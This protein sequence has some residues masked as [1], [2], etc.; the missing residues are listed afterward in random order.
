MKNTV[1]VLLVLAAG[2]AWGSAYFV[3]TQNPLANDNH[4]GTASAPFKTIQKAATIAA[5][6][7]TVYVKAGTYNERVSVNRSGAP[8]AR[9]VFKAVPRRTVTMQGFQLYGNY[10]RI[11]GF[12]L[13]NA[14]TGWN[15][16]QGIFNRQTGIQV[17]D[18]YLYNLTRSAIEGGDSAYIAHNHIYH[19]AFGISVGSN[20][21]VEYNDVERLYDYGNQDADYSR[22]GGSHI[23][24]RYNRY[25]G[26]LP[27]EKKTSHTDCWQ[28][29]DVNGTISTDIV[30][31][32]NF[33]SA[34]NQGL[35]GEGESYHQSGR[36]TFKN[37]IF[38]DCWS[39]GLCVQDIFEITAIHNVFAFIGT[40]G[41]GISGGY[42][43]NNIIKNNIFYKCG[44]RTYEF[45]AGSGSVGDYNIIYQGFNPSVP[46]PH[47]L[48]QVDPLFVDPDAGDFRLLPNSPA[49]DAGSDVGLTI[50]YAG[51]LRPQ[52]AGF[53]IGPYEADRT[54]PLAPTGLTAP[55]RT[56]HI[57]ALAW[58]AP[59]AASDG[60]LAAGYVIKRG[61]VH[62]GTS[63]TT[64]FN[65]SN[66]NASTSYSYEVYA[67]DPVGNISTGAATGNFQT[68]GDAVG[69][70]VL[71]AL[72]LSLT[73]VQV[74]FDEPV[75]QATSE[76]VASYQLSGGLTVSSATRQADERSVIVTTSAQT[77][78]TQYTITVRNVRDALT[79]HNT[80]TQSQHQF[81][82]LF[83]FEDDFEAGNT[84]KWT[85]ASSSVWTV[86][87]DAGDKSL[88]INAVVPAE[89]L[90]VNRNYSVLS[91]DADLKGYGASAYRN[92]SI[93]IGLQDTSNFYHINFAGSAT[94]AYNGIFKVV[95]K[96]ESR[97]AT[98]AALL[99]ETTQYHH[100]RVT[101]DGATGEIK[102]Y[103]DQSYTPAFSV[104]DTTYRSGK[105]GLWS[106]GSKQ[107]YFDN[108][109]VVERLRVDNFGSPVGIK[110]MPALASRT[111][112]PAGLAPYTTDLR[113]LS[114]LLGTQPPGTTARLYSMSGD[115]VWQWDRPGTY[116]HG[117]N[118]LKSGLYFLAREGQPGL[119]RVVLIK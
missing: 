77:E 60:D 45:P 103:F 104:V 58:T 70:I 33:C 17:V 21:I 92:L 113:Q 67:V 112:R 20:S 29:F 36:F 55:S 68:I 47:D 114:A 44:E 34:C 102:A 3:D 9:I 31:E 62:V 32:R 96:V 65:D 98:A 10:L 24:F 79:A 51:D 30:M 64:A 94:T 91:F 97:L 85:P 73:K 2:A 89:R 22:F 116:G 82:A 28:C 78:G 4:P 115:L 7:E 63:A 111:D 75:E 74:F 42:A 27:E 117:Q 25:H 6:G 106:K 109:E 87:D 41:I 71:Q 39:W 119:R 84:A 90:L 83:K 43:K 15:T 110:P 56:A 19:C 14:L 48:L 49:I 18:N 11:E 59:A 108:V 54:P 38:Y 107:G 16:G 23:I 37:N 100:V 26:T 99:T 76:A 35:M 52:G 66:L 72:S 8:N 118:G 105:C 93:I 12:N 50:D 46:G 53:D 5:A 69:P 57:I 86:T 80:M 95:N 61:T 1:M 40:Q 13:T 88:F 101:W 81:T